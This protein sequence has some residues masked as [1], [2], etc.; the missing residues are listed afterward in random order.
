MGSQLDRAHPL[1]RHVDDFLA[2]LKN[3]DASAHTIRAY[4]GD[5]A[6]FAAYHD[7]EVGELTAKPVRAYLSEIAGLAPSTRKRK[8]AAVASFCKW[9]VRHET[10]DTSVQN[11]RYPK[12][13]SQM[14]ELLCMR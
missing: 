14:S 1:A 2:D 10:T 7:G 12:S 5:L 6:Q 8:R 9:A 13:P 11:R 4:R 3:A